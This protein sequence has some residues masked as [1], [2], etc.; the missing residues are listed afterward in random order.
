MRFRCGPTR[1]ELEIISIAEAEDRKERLNR[2]RN[3]HPWFAWRPVQIEP[4]HC[5]W[6]E[7]IERREVYNDTPFGGFLSW[8]YRPIDEGS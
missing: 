8:D 2:R 5:R 1:Q 3:W 7:I 4:G 6:L